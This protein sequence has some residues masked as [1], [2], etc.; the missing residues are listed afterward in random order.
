M[1]DATPPA[2]LTL[3]LWATNVA[4]PLADLDAWLAAVD[5]RLA[6]AAAA[7]AELLLM[8]EYACM[9]WLSFAPEQVRSDQ[10]IAWMARQA[11]LALPELDGLAR[12]HGVALLA[13]TMPVARADGYQNQ[14]QLLLPEGR[15]LT[16]TKLC[17]TPSELRPDDWCLAPGDTLHVGVWRGLRLAIVVCL[18]IELPALAARLQHQ[19]LDLILVPSMTGRLSGYHRVAACARARAIELFTAVA[20]VGTVGTLVRQGKP[21]PNVAGAAVYLPCEAALGTSGIAGSLDPLAEAE[22]PGPLLL[23]PDIPIARIR[24]LR[25]GGA[26]EAWPGPWDAGHV[27]VVA[28]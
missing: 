15:R 4:L 27:R 23:V 21:E 10:E 19:D 1:S 5:L 8:P 25:E 7:G 22:G 17:L 9:Q 16:Q 14:A 2:G 26:A 12:R 24:R 28:L 11:V 18:D 13:G 20:T 6:E 3:A